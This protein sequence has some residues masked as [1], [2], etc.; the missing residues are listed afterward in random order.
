MDMEDSTQLID[1][2]ESE[3][4]HLTTEIQHTEHLD[5]TLKY[6]N[7]ENTEPILPIAKKIEEIE[8]TLKYDDDDSA[9]TTKST[10]NSKTEKVPSFKIAR[11]EI[12]EEETVLTKKSS[13]N[14]LNQKQKS[15]EK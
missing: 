7:E 10:S 11:T 1:N 14:N 15:V 5:P 4:N 9:L 12:F 8:P 6:E 2:T 3:I 13:N